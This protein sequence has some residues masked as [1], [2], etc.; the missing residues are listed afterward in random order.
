MMRHVM[1]RTHAPQ[2][3]R[4]A[5]REKPSARGE[6]VNDACTCASRPCRVSCLAPSRPVP[7]IRAG[8]TAFFAVEPPCSCPW[9]G[10]CFH[11]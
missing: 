1:Y 3:G 8:S 7:R 4:D 9:R 5:A 2:V 6:D 11:K 10:R